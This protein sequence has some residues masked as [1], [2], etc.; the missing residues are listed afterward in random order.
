MIIKIKRTRHNIQT[1]S[2]YI[3]SCTFEIDPMYFLCLAILVHRYGHFWHKYWL[4][5]LSCGMCLSLITREQLFNGLLYFNYA[6]TCV[7]Y[8]VRYN[9]ANNMI[10]VFWPLVILLP[11]MFNPPMQ[12]IH[13]L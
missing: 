3:M 10:E 6:I 9:Y 5:I 8:H 7:F 13:Y 1:S 4:S 2:L 12:N 11:V